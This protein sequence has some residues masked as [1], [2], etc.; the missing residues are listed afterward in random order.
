MQRNDVFLYLNNET[1]EVKNWLSILCLLSM[2]ATAQSDF[3]LDRI[4]MFE[5]SMAM[6]EMIDCIEIWSDA[7]DIKAESGDEMAIWTNSGVVVFHHKFKED[8]NLLLPLTFQFEGQY[9]LGYKR[10][11]LSGNVTSFQ[12]MMEMSSKSDLVQKV[13]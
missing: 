2:S 4:N 9:H 8:T 10:S 11:G 13:R 1:N 7:I 6:V 3:K 12:M 5:G